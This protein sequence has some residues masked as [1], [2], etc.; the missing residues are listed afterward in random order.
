MNINSGFSALIKKVEKH[1][2]KD[3]LFNDKYLIIKRECDHSVLGLF[4]YYVTNLSWIEFALRHQI[5][6]VIDMKNYAN[7]FHRE[8]E[9]KLIHGKCSLNNLV[10][11]AWKRH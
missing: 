1:C 7:T 3:N 6:P 10:V 8:N 4:A 9:V 2:G 5:T 11:L